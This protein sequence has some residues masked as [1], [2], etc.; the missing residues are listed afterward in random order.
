MLLADPA[1]CR[2]C[3]PM[4]WQKAKNFLVTTH[5]QQPSKHA[6]LQLRCMLYEHSSWPAASWRPEADGAR[7]AGCLAISADIDTPSAACQQLARRAFWGPGRAR[8]PCERPN[9]HLL[10]SLGPL[11]FPG[12]GAAWLRSSP[13][14]RGARAACL[15]RFSWLL[16]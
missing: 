11:P 10:L 7:A 15:L 14:L 2:A 5:L 8:P 3:K 1:A 13:V 16:V 12:Q 6:Y 4:E 9:C